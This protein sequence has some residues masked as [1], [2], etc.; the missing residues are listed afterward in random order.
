L[1]STTQNLAVSDRDKRFEL[2]RSDLAQKGVRITSIETFKRITKTLRYQELEVK[3][4]HYILLAAED[5]D[6]LAKEKANTVRPQP[7]EATMSESL[8]TYSEVLKLTGIRS[9]STIS[10][11]PSPDMSVV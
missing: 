4:P 11:S 3:F 9:R 10:D 5:G 2:V 8:L 7:K 6:E 1:L